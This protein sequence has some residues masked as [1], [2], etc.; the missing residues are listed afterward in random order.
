MEE[1]IELWAR[2]GKA[3]ISIK[4]EL[5]YFSFIKRYKL[6]VLQ[7][8]DST[9]YGSKQAKFTHLSHKYFCSP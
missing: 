2:A 3:K 5:C 9:W 4:Q 6:Q 1:I 8:N 7:F